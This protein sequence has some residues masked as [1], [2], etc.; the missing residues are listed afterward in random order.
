MQNKLDACKKEVNKLHK[1]LLARACEVD[2]KTRELADLKAQIV[3]YQ[4]A[5]KVEDKISEVRLIMLI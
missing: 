3:D 1:E 5:K 4:N 2:I